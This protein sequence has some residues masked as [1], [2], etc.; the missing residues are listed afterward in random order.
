MRRALLVALLA[1][2]ASGAALDGTVHRFFV[3]A[4]TIG[5]ERSAVAETAGAGRDHTVLT[6]VGALDDSEDGRYSVYLAM[7]RAAPGAEVV[8]DPATPSIADH[9]VK[10]IGAAGTV[11]RGSLDADSLA[12]T[13][14]LLRTREDDEAGTYRDGPWELRLAPGPVARLHVLHDGTATQLIDARLLPGAGDGAPAPLSAGDATSA[15]SA[16]DPPSL[17]R[18][19][20][21]ETAI[22]LLLLL[23][24]GLLLPRDLARPAVRMPLALIVGIALLGTSG[25]ARLPGLWG[26]VAAVTVGAVVGVAARLRGVPIG[27]AR[28][29]GRWLVAGIVGLAGIVTWARWFTFV[30]ITADSHNY[31][32]GGAALADGLTGFSSVTVKRGVA[33]QALHAPAFALGAEGLQSVGAVVLA[34]TVVLLAGLLHRSAGRAG[35]ISAVLIGLTAVASPQLRVFA[36]YVNAHMLVAAFLLALAVL[37]A[38]DRTGQERA[39]LPAIVALSGAVVLSRAEGP[40][41]VGLMLLGT[42]AVPSD[43]LRFSGA[44]RALGVLV[45]T[46]FALLQSGQPGLSPAFALLAATGT[47]ALLAPDVLGRLRPAWQ[48][49]VPLIAGVIL[50]GITAALLVAGALGLTRNVFIEVAVENLGRGDG[51]W[52]TVGIGLLLLAVVVIALGGDDDPGLAPGRW[53]LIG[54]V[55]VT[56]LAK[57]GDHGQVAGASWTDLF[58]GGG[59]LG[60]DDSVNR[61]WMHAVLVVL[62]LAVLHL[63]TGRDSTVSR[64]SRSSQ[65]T[66]RLGVVRTVVLSFVAVWIALQWQ[67]H[68]LPRPTGFDVTAAVVSGDRPVGELVDGAVVRQDVSAATVDLPAGGVPRAVCVDVR[69]VT[70]GRTNAGTLTL[71]V[72]FDG[73]T[74]TETFA[75]ADLVDWEWRRACVDLDEVDTPVVLGPLPPIIVEVRAEGAPPGAAVSVLQADT[76]P[77]E[78]GIGALGAR[79]RAAD[80]TGTLVDTVT[81]PLVME[82]VVVHDPPSAPLSRAIDRVAL[83]LPWVIVALGGGIIVAGVAKPSRLRG[84]ARRWRTIAIVALIPTISRERLIAD[85]R[86][87]DAC[88]VIEPAYETP[89]PSGEGMTRVSE[90]VVLTVPDVLLVGSAGLPVTRSGRVIKEPVS[91]PRGHLYLPAVERAVAELGLWRLLQLVWFPR[92][93]RRA[94]EFPSIAAGVHVI[95]RASP[96]PG[97]S[98]YAHW[99]LEQAAQIV[100]VETVRHSLPADLVYVTNADVAPYQADLFDALDVPSADVRPHADVVLRCESLVIATLRNGHSV[101]SEYDPRSARR[102]RSRLARLAGESPVGTGAG[103]APRLVAILRAGERKRRAVN[104]EAVERVLKEREGHLLPDAMPL[105]EEVGTLGDCEVMVGIHGAG[106]IKMLFAPRLR[107]LIELFPP[108]DRSPTLYEH[109]AVGLGVRYRRIVGTL[110]EGARE[111]GKNVDFVVP[112]DELEA[113]L[114]EFVTVPDSS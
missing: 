21:V 97:G 93:A 35:P 82:V 22:M 55:P 31:L 12:A 10:A 100:A 27:W 57:L 16:D 28:G 49:R 3:G 34:A 63:R 4:Q 111:H 114:D 50:W 48:Q 37:L 70:F 75:A 36:A 47:L 74:G 78:L 45:L 108:V 25:L 67:P 80:V 39:V 69:I 2:L 98:Q 1:V 76:A 62:L 9:Y 19:V 87:R 54:F 53:L 101:G 17:V 88:H 103:A 66:S 59:R 102:L 105:V 29:D 38:A 26:L 18:A 51:R 15:R 8:V 65:H 86:R 61:M 73:I 14:V 104:L 84:F 52:G 64:A 42:L 56:M 81:G 89:S 109:L 106:L 32:A 110:P 20:T 11:R 43:R 41:L 7:R 71:A 107:E 46:W 33:Q 85:A 83:L 112:I 58:S 60:W 77:V 30:F 5:Q 23:A 40:L 24:G 72:T 99:F 92:R 90:F 68:A 44:W 96:R 113:A 91:S 95:T 94:A 13:R 79:T 6:L